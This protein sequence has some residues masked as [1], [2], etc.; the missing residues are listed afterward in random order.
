MSLPGRIKIAK[1]FLYSQINYLGCFLPL[2]HKYSTDISNLIEDYVR[3]NLKIS[4]QRM[5]ETPEN[6]GIGLFNLKNFLASQTC[7][8][9]KRSV[10]PN[11]LWKKELF[12]FSYGSVF[13][14]R[15]S[16]IDRRLNPILYNIVDS[17][18]QF[19][20]SFTSKNENFF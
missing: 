8:W 15:K 1:T 10:V 5:Y 9:I 13:N 3:G 2:N 7:A 12:R 19:L 18:E 17:Y 4:K 11:D 16:T 14:I 6:G 20:F